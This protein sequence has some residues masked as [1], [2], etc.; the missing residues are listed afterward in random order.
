[1]CA[2][3]DELGV[4]DI[5][6][7]RPELLRQLRA[8]GASLLAEFAGNGNA[9]GV[10]LLLGL[11]VDIAASY[12]GD[13]Y[14]DIAWNSTALHVAAW[15]ARP[16]VVRPLVESGAAVN[17]PDGYGRSP[18]ALAVHA[19]VDSYWQARRT[20]ESVQALLQAGASL[21]SVRFPCGYRAVDD[22]LEAH[23]ARPA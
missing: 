3:N 2:R 19:C 21:S 20:P 10:R 7:R 13:G 18:L 22:L 15:R 4:H 6:G 16:A 14:F 23:G 9:K 1:M 8:G 11:G 5:V 12:Q 17:A